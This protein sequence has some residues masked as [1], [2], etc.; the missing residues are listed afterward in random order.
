MKRADSVIRPGAATTRRLPANPRWRRAVLPVLAGITLPGC[1]VVQR[2]DDMLGRHQ[3]AAAQLQARHDAFVPASDPAARRA[4]QE[5]DRVWLAGPVQP[6]A[7][8]AVLPAALQRHVTT[9]LLF[10]DEAATLPV[11]AERIARATGIPVRVMPDALLPAEAFLPRLAIDVPATA[12][13]PFVA[14]FASGPQPLPA[15]LDAIAHRLG[16]QWRFRDG[17]IEF[18]RVDSRVFDLR[19]LAMG[20]RAQARLG[21]SANIGAGGFDSASSTELTSLDDPLPALRAR[22]EALLTQAGTVV[23]QAGAGTAVVVTDT[24]EAL[25]R[26]A[27][28]VEREN[29]VLTRRVRLVFEEITLALDR[30]TE[31]GIDW[32]FIQQSS[33]AA[34][35]L[36][37][38]SLGAANEAARLS[39]SLLAGPMKG[40][41]A[42][43]AA[44]AQIGTVLRHTRVPVYT[45]NRRPVTHAVRTTFSYIDQAQTSAAWGMGPSGAALPT[46][47]VSQKQ[48]TTGTFLTLLPDAQ[49]DGQILLSVSYDNTVAQPLKTITFGAQDNQMQVQQLAIDGSGTVQQVSV[50][51]GQPVVIAGFDRSEDEGSRRR[52]FEG[53]P[54]LSGG[55]DR[56]ASQRTTTVIMVAADIEEGL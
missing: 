21:R 3:A 31:G 25:D 12:A 50:R 19:L 51:P 42:I 41:E 11:L 8:D 15:M 40:S 27:Q 39:T 47:S 23:L 9:T 32:R 24:R 13:M 36:T 37:G 46:V 56:A 53:L 35:A 18:Y 43:V 1:S 5:V 52:A 17:I 28:F 29:R 30:G 38:A 2:L 14:S 54:L 49:D 34:A 33:R 16:V 45:L 26:V 22:I 20:A 10:A 7:R 48:E 55:R 6:L 44:L 4:A